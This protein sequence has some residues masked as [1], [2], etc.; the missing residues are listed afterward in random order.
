MVWY[1]Q[2]THFIYVIWIIHLTPF[3][4]TKSNIH[5]YLTYLLSVSA[6]NRYQ[7]NLFVL[8]IIKWPQF[9]RNSLLRIR[10]ERTWVK[11]RL[12]NAMQLYHMSGTLFLLIELQHFGWKSFIKNA[13]QI[14]RTN[15][16]TRAPL[17]DSHSS[18]STANGP[19][20]RYVKLRIA[21]APGMPGTFSLSPRV[22]DP[23]M[24]HGT[25][26]TYVPWYMPGSLTSGFFDVSGGENIPGITG[27]CA[28]LNFT[29]L[30]RSPWRTRAM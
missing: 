19:L 24:H 9:M 15:V 11:F 4:D 16:L 27:A 3:T 8:V 22:S 12:F 14:C 18:W 13:S 23:D 29:Y 17:C 10:Y 25:C 1:I 6:V 21:H 20:T 2:F 5:N 7:S 30:V 28:T 26:V